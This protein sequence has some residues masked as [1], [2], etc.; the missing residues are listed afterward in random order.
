[1][2]KL[3]E[4]RKTI[5]QVDES[6]AKLFEKR[7]EAAKQVAQHKKE[8]GL[9][10]EDKKREEKLIKAMEEKVDGQFKPYYETFL[11]KVIEISKDYQA[12][13]LEGM[14][15]AYSGVE[16]AFAHI[17][18]GK[19]F[20]LKNT[21]SFPDF[22]SAY[23][24]VVSGECDCAVLPIENSYAGDVD[25][26]IDLSY[27]GGLHVAGI[28]DMP[29]TQSLLAKKGVSI[30]EIKEVESH[31]Q[32]ISQC[33]PY[34]KSHGWKLKETVNTAVAAKKIA[35]NKRRDKAVIAA[36]EAAEIYG[37]TVLEGGINE[38]KNNTTRFAVFTR[39]DS[40][41]AKDDNNFILL[42]TTKNTPGALGRAISIVSE[43]G[44]NLRC[45]KSRPTGNENWAYYFYAEG[46]G[47][48]GTKNGE[49]MIKE[50]KAVCKDVRLLGSFKGEKL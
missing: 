28:Y 21:I 7:M 30:D 12:H 27:N 29:L 49:N 3:K 40:K 46:E 44:Y 9:P 19:I 16:G 42:F 13:L 2:N 20:D 34:L 36:R 47:N 41:V 37:L 22:E 11:T 10:I 43:N 15:V 48:I 32:A 38:N 18:S 50:L 17:A 6:M 35:E 1:M 23:M 8:N 4:A 39:E 25:S 24:A 5:D 31:P 14:K 33:M 26:V 45:L